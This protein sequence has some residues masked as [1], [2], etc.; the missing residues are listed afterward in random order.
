MFITSPESEYF[1]PESLKTLPGERS[2]RFLE[3]G[4]YLPI[5]LV[6]VRM[7][8]DDLEIG[9]HFLFGQVNDVLDLAAQQSDKYSIV[10]I[11]L[12]SPGYMNSGNGYEMKQI[13][14]IWRD[15]KISRNLT[16]V[17]ADGS[18]VEHVFNGHEDDEGTCDLELVLA[19]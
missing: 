10:Y 11:Q 6:A 13:K 16:F 8:E 18:R 17:M 5:F 14:E 15:K 4:L 7:T 9:R 3:F 1:V 2:W 12:L 19:A